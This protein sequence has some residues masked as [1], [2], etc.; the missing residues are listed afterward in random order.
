VR[1]ILHGYGY[2]IPDGRGVLGGW[3]PLP[4]PWL[5]PGFIE[6]GFNDLTQNTDMIH[7]LM[8]RFNN[9]LKSVAA[10]FAH[11]RYVDFRGVLPATKT[12]WANELHPEATGFKLAAK[13]LEKA[14]EAP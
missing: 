14:I 9:M 13:E 8:D 10:D 12:L 5:R 1:I 6:K 7:V 3:G 11:V 2:A 4:G